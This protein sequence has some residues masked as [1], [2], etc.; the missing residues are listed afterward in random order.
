[1]HPAGMFFSRSP[2]VHQGGEGG[3]VQSGSPAPRL[4]AWEVTRRCNLSCV[5]CRAAA[6]D[7]SHPGEL[8]TGEGRRLLGEL[9]RLGRPVVILTGGEPLMR[10]D[11]LQL[12]RCGSDLGLRVVL[13]TNGTLLDRALAKGLREAG[14]KRISISI[15][16]ASPRLHDALRRSPGAFEGA[17]RAMEACAAEGLPFQINTTFTRS[18]VGQREDMYDFV[19]RSGAVAWHVFFLVEVGR[20]EVEGEQL[21][22][23]EYEAT[24]T[25]LVGRKA[26]G[27]VLVKVTCAPQFERIR[28]QGYAEDRAESVLGAYCCGAPL[29]DE[30]G[31]VTA[32]LSVSTPSI[33]MTPGKKEEIIRAVLEAVQEGE[34][35]IQASLLPAPGRG[36]GG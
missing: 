33:R 8:T 26:E 10:P 30:K 36:G 23:A 12:V 22:P 28:R 35:R 5:Y 6:D 34:R 25:W 1:M 20:G 31:R 18:N 16:A 29:R 15:D 7:L 27:K 19:C 2:A 11:I 13:A 9:A 24:L 21:Q 17:L 4:V 3:W 32:A 14:L